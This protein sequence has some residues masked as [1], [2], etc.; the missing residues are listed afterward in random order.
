MGV[1]LLLPNLQ[2]RLMP[3]LGHFKHVQDPVDDTSVCI[4]ESLHAAHTHTHTLAFAC[5]CSSQGGAGDKAL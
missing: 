3:H 2:Q 4:E 1:Y 5:V